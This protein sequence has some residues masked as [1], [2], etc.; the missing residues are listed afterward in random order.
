MIRLLMKII[1]YCINYPIAVSFLVLEIAVI[2]IV[3]MLINRRRKRKELARKIKHEKEIN[4]FY[5][6]ITNPEWLRHGGRLLEIPIE[7]I[8]KKTVA[9]KKID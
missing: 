5:K 4:S 3:I 7:N 6:E 2:V 1:D 8:G 9:G